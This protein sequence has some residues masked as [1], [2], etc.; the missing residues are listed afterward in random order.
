M[1]LY[2]HRQGL[3]ADGA[4]RQLVVDAVECERHLRRWRRPRHGARPEIERAFFPRTR[5]RQLADPSRMRNS[6]QGEVVSPAKTARQDRGRRRPCRMTGSL[7]H[8][9][10]QVG[11]HGVALVAAAGDAGHGLRQHCR[12]LVSRGLDE[13]PERGSSVGERVNSNRLALPCAGSALPPRGA[14]GLGS[15]AK[16]NGDGGP[17]CPPLRASPRAHSSPLA[18]PAA[19][20]LFHFKLLGSCPPFRRAS[21]GVGPAQKRPT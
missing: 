5:W 8:R 6:R 17:A 10:V 9:F 16:R 12:A 13:E 19:Y 20:A 2:L 14:D 1:R 7:A 11:R 3:A 18:P 21:F 15:S 4:D